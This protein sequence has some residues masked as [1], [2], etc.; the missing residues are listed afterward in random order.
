M[1][2][3]IVLWALG[4]ISGQYSVMFCSGL[5]SSFIYLRFYQ[6]HGNG[7][8]GTNAENFTFARYDSVRSDSATS[9]NVAFSPY[10][11]SFFPTKLQPFINLLVNPIYKLS[12]HVGLV[13]HQPIIPLNHSST[14]DLRSLTMSISPSDQ[15]DNERRRAIALK[16]LNERWKALNADASK[17]QLPKSFPQTTATAA[18]KSTHQHQGGFSHHGHSHERKVIPKFNIDEIMKPIPLPPP[19]GMMSSDPSTSSIQNLD[20]NQPSSSND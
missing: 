17:S 9:A 16:A 2:T 13:K 18:V 19:P 5:V 6:R 10:H 7:V 14:S 15:Q 11:F 20:A 8:R 4:L 3:S 12:L 1:V